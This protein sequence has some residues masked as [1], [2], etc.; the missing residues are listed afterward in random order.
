MPKVNANNWPASH[1]FRK[2]RPTFV[3][4]FNPIVNRRNKQLLYFFNSPGRLDIRN[5]SSVYQFYYF[6]L[7][8]Q[9]DPFLAFVRR[10]IVQSLSEHSLSDDSGT[11]FAAK[12]LCTLIRMSIRYSQAVVCGGVM[13]SLPVKTHDN[14]N[15]AAE[16]ESK[17]RIRDRR[18]LYF[19]VQMHI[20]QYVSRPFILVNKMPHLQWLAAKIYHNSVETKI[21]LNVYSFIYVLI[22]F[23][24]IFCSICC[25]WSRQVYW[26]R[27]TRLLQ[28]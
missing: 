5:G 22:Y 8:G 10:K 23:Y 21:V 12:Q 3:L 20:M 15:C 17:S 4:S 19:D 16:E 7:I 26:I 25:W 11:L 14:V 13:F 6:S 18:K 28:R 27:K 2:L 1:I 24:F 9:I